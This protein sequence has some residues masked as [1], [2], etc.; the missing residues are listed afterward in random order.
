[1]VVF[2]SIAALWIQTWAQA[3]MSG[4][5]AAIVMTLEPVFAAGFAVTLGDESAKWRMI[6]GGALVLMAMYAAELLGRRAPGQPPTEA[7]HH[8]S[9]PA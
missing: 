9:P 7:F 3:H 8:E 6:I 4:T 1:M 2:A 5:R